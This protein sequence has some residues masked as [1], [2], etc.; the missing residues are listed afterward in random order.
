MFLLPS[1]D[2][3]LIL[4]IISDSMVTML[5]SLMYRMQVFSTVGLVNPVSLPRVRLEYSKKVVRWRAML[6]PFLLKNG[7]LS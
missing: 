5:F 3:D 2:E 7:V 1:R 4:L 6:G